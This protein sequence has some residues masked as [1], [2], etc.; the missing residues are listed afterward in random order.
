MRT[1]EGVCVA[2][3]DYAKPKH[4]EID[5]P[6]LQVIKLMTSLKSR[7]YVYMLVFIVHT[8]RCRAPH[9]NSLSIT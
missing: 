4:D 9:P 8:F 3:K 7:G 2:K 6:N 1:T 5:V